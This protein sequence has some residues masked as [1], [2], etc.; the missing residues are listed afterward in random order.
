M[1]RE[2]DRDLPMTEIT[3]SDLITEEKADFVLSEAKEQLNATVSDAEALTKAGVYLLGGLLT[4]VTALFGVAAALFKSGRSV[5]D[6]NWGL[7]LPLLITILYATADAAMVMWTALSSK[8]LEHGGNMPKNLATTELFE[9]EIR[10]IKFSEAM[11][12]QARIQKNHARNEQ[13][14]VTINRGIKLAC[15]APLIYLVLTILLY[16][17]APASFRP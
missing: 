1:P 10:L 8:E 14:G 7:I 3:N 15:L 17:I 11:S 5:T 4:A 12:Y 9:L 13:I 2:P 6:Q 16:V